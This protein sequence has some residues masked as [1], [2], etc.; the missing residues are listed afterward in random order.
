MRSGSFPP[1]C[2]WIGSPANDS[3]RQICLYEPRANYVYPDIFMSVIDRHALSQQD[4]CTF[5]RCM[6]CAVPSADNSKRGSYVNNR[7][8]ANFSHVRQRGPRE[9]PNGTN[10]HIE[11]VVPLFFAYL[12]GVSKVQDPRVVQQKV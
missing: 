3:R 9:L 7:T 5:G 10:V 2:C 1:N 12:L 4:N 11:G 8:A 6:S